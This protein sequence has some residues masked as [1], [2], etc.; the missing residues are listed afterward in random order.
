MPSARDSGRQPFH[1]EPTVPMGLWATAVQRD[2]FSR[3]YSFETVGCKVS[4]ADHVKASQTPVAPAAYCPGKSKPAL[5]LKGIIGTSKGVPWS[6]SYIQLADMAV[7]RLCAQAG[8]ASWGKLGR[9]WLNRLML[10]GLLVRKKVQGVDSPWWWSLGDVESQAV[11]LWQKKTFSHGGHYPAS[12]GSSSRDCYTWGL[13]LDHEKS[14][15]LPVKFVSHRHVLAKKLPSGLLGG[16]AIA[17]GEPVP[18]LQAAA[19]Q[20]FIDFPATLLRKMCGDLG[21][22][23]S[24]SMNLCELLTA[25][26]RGSTPFTADND[27]VEILHRRLSP[28]QLVDSDFWAEEGT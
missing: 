22:Q 21:I 12:D 3:L 5:P 8:S 11:L 6:H 14:A 28:Q 16:A 18:L 7:F 13:V 15:A 1:R 24:C 27:L 10:P 19:R 20:G 26:I 9:T 25:A 17:T 2:L 23:V 4:P